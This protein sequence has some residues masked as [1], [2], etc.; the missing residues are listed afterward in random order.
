MNTDPLCPQ[1]HTHPKHNPNRCVF[2][3]Y[4]AAVRADERGRA[5]GWPDYQSQRDGDVRAAA[6]RDA[7]AAVEALDREP[8]IY[9][10]EMVPY[11]SLP[12]ALAAIRARGES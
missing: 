3:E 12:E 2:C 5:Y 9:E 4:G 10:D 11:V 7:V 8:L 6:L 1:Q